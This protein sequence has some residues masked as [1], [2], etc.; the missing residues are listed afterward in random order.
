MRKDINRIETRIALGILDKINEN[1]EIRK[2]VVIDY[3]LNA[4]G[5]KEEAEENPYELN[6]KN[7]QPGELYIKDSDELVYI[8]ANNAADKKVIKAF[9]ENDNSEEQEMTTKEAKMQARDLLNNFEKYEVT[10][11]EKDDIRALRKLTE[12]KTI[13]KPNRIIKLDSTP[14][15]LSEALDTLIK[16][17]IVEEDNFSNLDITITK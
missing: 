11:I 2:D 10:E 13:I 3:V 14:Y 17:G 12:E 9:N 8:N 4:L 15:G 5:I 16:Y 1:E 7:A 6:W